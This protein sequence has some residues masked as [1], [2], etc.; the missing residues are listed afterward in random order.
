MAPSLTHSLSHFVFVPQ[1]GQ[2]EEEGGEEHPY[3]GRHT[4]T[5][6]LTNTYQ[7]LFRYC[8]LKR[9]MRAKIPFSFSQLKMKKRKSKKAFALLL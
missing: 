3:Q 8:L 7:D 9:Y 2:C 6:T 1:Q 5:L 4:G